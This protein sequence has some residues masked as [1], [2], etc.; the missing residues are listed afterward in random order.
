MDEESINFVAVINGKKEEKL[1]EILKEKMNKC[2]MDFNFEE[3]AIYRDKI[4]SLED[5]MEK[6]KRQ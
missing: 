5:M 1:I 4:K 6:Q 2:A 3:A